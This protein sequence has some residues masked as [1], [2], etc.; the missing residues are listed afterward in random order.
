MLAEVFG[1]G[2][3]GRQ[4]QDKEGRRRGSDGV[5][6]Y[7]GWDKHIT[8][9]TTQLGLQKEEISKKSIR[10]NHYK[11]NFLHVKKITITAEQAVFP[12]AS[13]KLR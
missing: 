5:S 1:S 11:T 12:Q 3:G 13:T 10:L 9:A 2:R 6:H 7:A 4:R 8:R